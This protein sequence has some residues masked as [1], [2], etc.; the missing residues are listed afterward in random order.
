M[1]F[2]Y[3]N[4]KLQRNIAPKEAKTKKLVAKTMPLHI[5]QPQYGLFC[6]TPRNRMEILF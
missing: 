6:F 3:Y 4:A 2:F 5:L 1:V